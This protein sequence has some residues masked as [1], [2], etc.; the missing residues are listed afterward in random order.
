MRREFRFMRGKNI[1]IKAENHVPSAGTGDVP[2]LRSA[3]HIA[4][5]RKQA[6]ADPQSLCSP[7]RI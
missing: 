3:I 4:A 1:K 2:A 5:H 6:S 7:G